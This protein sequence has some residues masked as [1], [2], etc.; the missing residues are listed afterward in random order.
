MTCWCDGDNLVLRALPFSVCGDD[1]LAVGTGR[2]ECAA[3]TGKKPVAIVLA[4]SGLR[5]QQRRF[6]VGVSGRGSA[7]QGDG[8]GKGGGGNGGEDWGGNGDVRGGGQK[9]AEAWRSDTGSGSLSFCLLTLTAQDGPH[10]ILVDGARERRILGVASPI[11]L[12][13]MGPQTSALRMALRFFWK[14]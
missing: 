4:S 10:G 13:E 6:A 8:G 3:R 2:A 11:S 7:R 1:S 12:R 9:G 14:E 5:R